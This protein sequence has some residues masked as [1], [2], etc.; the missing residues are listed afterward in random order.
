MKMTYKIIM[1]FII[2]LS[3][4]IF[5][6]CGMA[7]KATASDTSV[8]QLD[9]NIFEVSFKENAYM[10]LQRK[11]DMILLKGAEVTYN[12]GYNYFTMMDEEKY[13]KEYSHPIS[14]EDETRIATKSKITK[15]III[16]YKDKPKEFSYNAKFL[17]DSLKKKYEHDN[18]SM[19]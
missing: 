8:I 7:A 16:C 9:Y 1:Y 3:G 18:E 17:I 15:K 10:D 5:Y 13:K 2:I 6:S 12:N 14:S 19:F 11:T 4:F